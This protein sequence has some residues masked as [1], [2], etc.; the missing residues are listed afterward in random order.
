MSAS[1]LAPC[2]SARLAADDFLDVLVDDLSDD[3]VFAVRFSL[4]MVAD[5]DVG[6][7]EMCQQGTNVCCGD[8]EAKGRLGPRDSGSK[9]IGK[10]RNVESGR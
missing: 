8:Q 4:T 9:P 1:L 5:F 7:F 3:L 6:D 10:L 2:F